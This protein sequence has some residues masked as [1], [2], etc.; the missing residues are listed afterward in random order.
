MSTNAL[1]VFILHYHQNGTC[2]K[3]LHSIQDIMR[4]S[5]PAFEKYKTF[6]ENLPNLAILTKSATPGEVQLTFAH[7]S[8][9]NKSLR[10]YVSAL[11]LTGSLNS[12]SVVSIKIIIVFSTDGEKICLPITEVLLCAAAGNIVWSKKQ[13]DWMPRNAVLIPPFLT[14]A[15][16]LDGGSDAGDLLKIFTQY[17]TERAEEGEENGG[18]DEDDYDNN[19]EGDKETEEYKKKEDREK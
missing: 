13:Q 1:S 8:V 14:E 15:T 10:E 6:C 17:V 7:A 11:A 9:G 16:I 5:E 2:N 3:N 18:D 19:S 4:T 12:L